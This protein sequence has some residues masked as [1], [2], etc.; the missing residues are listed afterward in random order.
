MAVL[1][2]LE[3]DR[4]YENAERLGTHMH[5]RLEEMKERFEIMGDNR[6]V[7]LMRATEFVEDGKSKKAAPKIR[8]RIVTDAFKHGL[9]MLS[10]GTS[11]IR[12]IPALNIPDDL[13]DA[14][15]DILEGA[16]R[17]AAK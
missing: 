11:A 6:G 16:I 17:R 4:L 10:A 7:G 8:D 14:G 2:I 5:R 3:Q 9:L 13:L 15:L 12:Y 1:D